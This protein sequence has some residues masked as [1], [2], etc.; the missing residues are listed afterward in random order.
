LARFAPSPQWQ[1]PH[2]LEFDVEEV[3]LPGR[4]WLGFQRAMYT[5]EPRAAGE[6]LVTRKTVVPSTLR[7]GFY[8]RFFEQLGTETEHDYNLSS[9]KMN[10]LQAE[11]N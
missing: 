7:P 6:T 4:Q 11:A 1:P 5:L 2:R 10:V 9:L 3:Q 8:W